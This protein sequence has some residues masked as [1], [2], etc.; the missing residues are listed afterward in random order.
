MLQAAGKALACVGGSRTYSSFLPDHKI[1]TIR[2]VYLGPESSF[3]VN[4][5]MYIFHTQLSDALKGHPATPAL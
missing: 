2:K 4:K 5:R 3:I 1:I